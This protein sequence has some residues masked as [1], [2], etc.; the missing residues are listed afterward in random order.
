[1]MGE[2]LSGLVVLICAVVTLSMPLWDNGHEEKQKAILAPWLVQQ[3]E[4]DF[5]NTDSGTLRQ[6]PEDE[7]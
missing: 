6:T 1:M 3:V 7:S 4:P 5:T 2:I